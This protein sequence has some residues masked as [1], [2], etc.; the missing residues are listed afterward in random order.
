MKTDSRVAHSFPLVPCWVGEDLGHPTQ[1][2][3]KVKEVSAIINHYDG[4]ETHWFFIDP[5]IFIALF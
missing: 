1:Q 3:L 2:W 5:S 4:L